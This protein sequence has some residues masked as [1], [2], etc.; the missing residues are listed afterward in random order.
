M[1]TEILRQCLHAAHV[2]GRQLFVTSCD[3]KAA[4]D[5]IRHDVMYEALIRQR[6]HPS[7]AKAILLEYKDLQANVRIADAP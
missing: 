3:I 7:L 2:W 1:V 4:F 5:H 6:V